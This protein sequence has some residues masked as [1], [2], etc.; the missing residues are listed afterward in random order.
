MLLFNEYLNKYAKEQPSKKLFHSCYGK[1]SVKIDNHVVSH[2]PVRVCNGLA[3]LAE[4]IM[5]P[6]NCCT[7]RINISL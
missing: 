7:S 6:A 2:F 3:D 1:N 4:T 5:N